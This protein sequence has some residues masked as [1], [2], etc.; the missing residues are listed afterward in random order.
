ML[1]KR[2]RNRDRAVLPTS[3]AD[4]DDYVRFSFRHIPRRQKIDCRGQ[5]LHQLIRHAAPE[6]VVAHFRI[7][8]VFLA[9]AHLIIGV[10]QEPLHQTPDPDSGGMP[11]FEAERLHDHLERAAAIRPQRTARAGA[12]AA[13]LRTV[14]RIDHKIR[15]AL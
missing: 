4:A 5:M 15:A 9:Q 3:T 8:T 14:S 10:G 7:G 2:L 13:P 1:G 11:Y 12:R 6:H